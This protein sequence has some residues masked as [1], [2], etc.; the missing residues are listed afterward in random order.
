MRMT[1]IISASVNVS[2]GWHITTFAALIAT[3]LQMK[4]EKNSPQMWYQVFAI[5]YTCIIS[6]L[7]CILSKVHYQL[8]G[9]CYFYICKSNNFIQPAKINQII[10]IMN[11]MKIWNKYI[12]EIMTS[13][14]LTLFQLFA[15]HTL[16]MAKSGPKYE[17]E[18]SQVSSINMALALG[19]RGC[20][21][22]P[23]QYQCSR[24]DW[25]CLKFPWTRNSLLTVS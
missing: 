20:E 6:L 3:S 14:N 12:S 7:C 17:K 5:N 25:V 11:K 16:Q 18:I 8:I 22:E 2:W 15:K 4:R 24:E 13:Q 9:R 19:V 23:S 10:K 21:F 1:M